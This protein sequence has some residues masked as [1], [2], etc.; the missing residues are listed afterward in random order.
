MRKEYLKL[1][2][3]WEIRLTSLPF[4][5]ESGNPRT[6]R[7]DS[8]TPPSARPFYLFH[9]RSQLILHHPPW[10]G[11]KGPG[12]LSQA[13]GPSWILRPGSPQA[14]SA[15]RGASRRCSRGGTTGQTQEHE[16]LC[17]GPWDQLHCS[18]TPTH[19]SQKYNTLSNEL[20]QSEGRG[21]S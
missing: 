19:M 14:G 8:C 1:R 18:G 13:L 17:Q 12:V 9:P 16:V 6:W 4:P 21:V 11:S 3:M 7:R 2:L 5:D 20:V 15:G 10:R